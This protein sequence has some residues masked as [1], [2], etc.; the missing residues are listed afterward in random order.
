MLES[1]NAKI[2]HARKYN[3]INNLSRTS[4]FIN[5]F[6]YDMYV[7]ANFPWVGLMKLC[8]KCSVKCNE[9]HG[10][11]QH[12]LQLQLW[13]KNSQRE[14]ICV[15]GMLQA[16]FWK[17]FKMTATSK[18]TAGVMKLLSQL[19]WGRCCMQGTHRSYLMMLRF[20]CGLFSPAAA[21]CWQQLMVP[22]D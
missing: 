4:F 10:P 18:W 20:T 12:A 16:L 22:S 2:K 21:T 5:C 8:L 7:F 9:T 1:R 3:W 15:L 19:I 17:T 14:V 6:C 13:D 11:A